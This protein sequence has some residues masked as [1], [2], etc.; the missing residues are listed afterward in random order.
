M[1]VHRATTDFLPENRENDTRKIINYLS[2]EKN[3]TEAETEEDFG[4][5]EVWHTFYKTW[6][7]F[8]SYAS[9]K[10][11]GQE[12]VINLWAR[13]ERCPFWKKA[14]VNAAGV[15]IREMKRSL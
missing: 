13:S 7:I 4:Y 14:G 6:Q 10:N 11:Y 9:S 2:I 5:N 3:E 8:L 15:K 12:I 1:Y